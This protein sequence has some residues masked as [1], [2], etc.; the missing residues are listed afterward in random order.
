MEST[1]RSW[2]RFHS[3]TKTGQ[4]FFGN[5]GEILPDFRKKHF[6]RNVS[7]GIVVSISICDPTDHWVCGRSLAGIVGLNPA[8]GM[9]VCLL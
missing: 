4:K 3:F 6:Y 2:E 5:V 1:A 7:S 9:D 8:G